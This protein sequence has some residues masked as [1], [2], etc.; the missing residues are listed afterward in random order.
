MCKNHGRLPVSIFSVHK[1]P[2]Y[3]PAT[4]HP[5]PLSCVK[6]YTLYTYTVCKGGRGMG[7]WASDK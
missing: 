1:V 7:F 4:L 6:K 5:P 3:K 2:I